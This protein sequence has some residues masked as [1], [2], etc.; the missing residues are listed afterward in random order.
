M[1]PDYKIFSIILQA[2]LGAY[3]EEQLE[4]TNE[5]LEWEF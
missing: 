3:V 2:R 4:T 5:V 1:N